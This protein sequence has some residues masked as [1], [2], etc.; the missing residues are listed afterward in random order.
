MLEVPIVP[1][2]RKALINLTFEYY[3]GKM[4]ELLSQVTTHRDLDLG[5][6]RFEQNWKRTL[7]SQMIIPGN[8]NVSLC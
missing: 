8:V 7:S 1:N 6:A 2:I 5:G 4:K 3:V